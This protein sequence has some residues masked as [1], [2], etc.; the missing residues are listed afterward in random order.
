MY[1]CMCKRNGGGCLGCRLC[2]LLL[3]ER[4]AAVL[5]RRRDGRHSPLL[6]LLCCDVLQCRCIHAIF[7]YTCNHCIYRSV[8]IHQ[9]SYVLSIWM[10]RFFNKM[11]HLNMFFI[12]ISGDRL[13]WWCLQVLRQI[14]DLAMHDGTGAEGKQVIFARSTLLSIGDQDDDDISRRL[15]DCAA[16]SFLKS[17][18]NTGTYSTYMHACMIQCVCMY[19][20]CCCSQMSWLAPLYSQRAS[21]ITSGWDICDRR[22]HTCC[23]PL[24]DRSS[25]HPSTC[26]AW[27]RLDPNAGCPLLVLRSVAKRRRGQAG[28]EGSSACCGLR[29]RPPILFPTGMRRLGIARGAF[30]GP[31]R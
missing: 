6:W 25:W 20:C 3:S 28:S 30:S 16:E 31:R 15:Q 29:C 7:F 18:L 19:L 10:S 17:L 26:T 13:Q 9:D 5:R 2:G 22:S 12:G 21:M 24:T 8:C 11:S 14:D 23:G 27:I 4:S 1:E